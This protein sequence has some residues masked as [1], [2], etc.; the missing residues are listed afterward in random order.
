[1]PWRWGCDS[2]RDPVLRHVALFGKFH[3]GRDLLPPLSI[4]SIREHLHLQAGQDASLD[5][6]PLS[7]GSLGNATANYPAPLYLQPR[8]SFRACSSVRM[9]TPDVTSLLGDA[10]RM[11]LESP[12]TFWAPSADMLS[13]IAPGMLVKVCDIQNAE[14]LWTEVVVKD[15]EKI[16]AT[17]ANDTAA[18]WAHGTLIQFHERCAYDVVSYAF[19]AKS[20]LGFELEMEGLLDPPSPEQQEAR[21]VGRAVQ[22][23]G[24]IFATGQTNPCAIPVAPEEVLAWFKGDASRL[25]GTGL[26]ADDLGIIHVM[27]EEEL[28]ADGMPPEI[29]RLYFHAP[30][31]LVLAPFRVAEYYES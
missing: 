16:T 17:V 3:P 29:A 2:E 8:G 21:M 23:H 5:A 9:S 12:G 14:R 4:P 25:E 31:N 27:S 26:S 11:A 18:R 24:D 20:A 30:A 15:G 19:M 13:A 28:A 10:Q 6:P 7:F 22:T 1:M